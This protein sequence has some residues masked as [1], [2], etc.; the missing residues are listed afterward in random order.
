MKPIQKVL[1]GVCYILVDQLDVYEECQNCAFRK[2][3]D[4]CQEIGDECN[5]PETMKMVWEVKKEML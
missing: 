4:L 1:R 5:T 3:G 2:R